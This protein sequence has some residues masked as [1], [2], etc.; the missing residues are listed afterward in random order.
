M[1]ENLLEKLIE[2]LKVCN[3]EFTMARPRINKTI[4]IPRIS[5]VFG[6]FSET[7]YIYLLSYDELKSCIKGEVDGS[8]SSDKYYLLF[9][10]FKSPVSS[11]VNISKLYI[12]F[13]T[14]L[15]MEIIHSIMD[16]FSFSYFNVVISGL[17]SI[18]LD[19]LRV[20]WKSEG[21]YYMSNTELRYNC[22]LI[23][24]YG[25]IDRFEN[26]YG[27]GIFI[28]KDFIAR[29]PGICFCV[30][31]DDKLDT[32]III[33]LSDFIEFRC[34]CNYILSGRRFDEVNKDLLSAI[35]A[36]LANDIIKSDYVREHGVSLRLGSAIENL[37]KLGGVIV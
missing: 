16:G 17:S 31:S 2:Y 3:L 12:E 28:T 25:T 20:Y 26:G 18:L 13:D 36:E 5:I 33:E 8:C 23:S 11:R 21:C 6:K 32:K 9:T 4:P 35:C 22:G 10:N 24:C 37:G 30:I 7:M 14:A 34:K 27:C 29:V 1:K 15:C 19:S